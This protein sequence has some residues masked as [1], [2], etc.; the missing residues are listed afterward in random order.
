MI[1]QQ[2]YSLLNEFS[3]EI[4]RFFDQRENPTTQWSPAIDLK[5]NE[6][7]YVIH[8]DIPGVKAEDIEVTLDNG[9]LSIRG[10][11]K[12]DNKEEG[13]KYKR[14]ERAYGSFFRRFSLP[15]TADS[16][17]VTAKSTDGVLE[18]EIPKQ[19]KAQPRRIEIQH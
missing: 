4:S 13:E 7:S 3:N 16:D 17:S 10:E 2:P 19:A 8:A 5:E 15:D 1:R 11:R 14:V 18:I 12:F 9:V 6:N